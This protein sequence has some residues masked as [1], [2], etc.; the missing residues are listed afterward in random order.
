MKDSEAVAT[1]RKGALWASERAG[2]RLQK[3]GVLA[4]LSTGAIMTQP[5][6]ALGLPGHRALTWLALLFIM[7]LVGG[8]GWATAV[9][10][11]SAVGTLAIGRSPDGS[12]WG[13][14]QYVV[15]GFGVDA[16]LWARPA[17]AAGAARMAAL[18]AAILLSV[19]WITPLGKSFLGAGAD[20][21]TVWLSITDVQPS[22]W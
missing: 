22:A 3:V 17:L 13:V 4:A 10:L 1:K 2:R 18:G 20:P 12:F 21:H 14:L 8:P 19:G 16:L 7:R 11:A 15:A 5:H 9:G 6:L